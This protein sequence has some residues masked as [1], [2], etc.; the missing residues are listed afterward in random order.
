MSA[1]SSPCMN[2]LCANMLGR[3]DALAGHERAGYL[4]IY[5]LRRASQSALTTCC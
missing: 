3:C 5:G 1:R 4:E 2:I